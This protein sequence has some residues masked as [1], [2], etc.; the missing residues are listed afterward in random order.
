MRDVMVD[1]ETTGRRPGCG[2]L[3][4]GAVRFDPEAG[5]LGDTFYEVVNRKSCVE[6][7][8]REDPAT[9]AW[10]GRQSAQPAAV[11]KLAGKKSTSLGLTAALAALAAFLYPSG[12][13]V[14]VWGC[15][16]S[17]DN[18]I[19]VAAYEAIGMDVPW[20]FWNDRC[21]RTLKAMGP[22]EAEPL[23]EGTHHN[24][25][26]DAVHQA[27]HACNVFWHLRGGG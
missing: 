23:R 25:L 26:D 11:L 20:Q 10:W 3:S 14:R 2:I 9:L 8:L 15:G 7:G 27:K 16:A 19:L 22:R 6:A 4:I 5:A 21:H 1:L 12:R 13:D 24:A 18:A 17:F